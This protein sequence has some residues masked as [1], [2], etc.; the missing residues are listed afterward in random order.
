MCACSKA[1]VIDHPTKP[2]K[3]LKHGA[4]EAP[5]WS[6]HYRGSTDKDHITLPDYW[7]GLV[8]DDSVTAMLTPV[9]EHQNLYVVSQDNNHICVGGVTGCYNYIVYG[10]RK[11]ISKLEVETDG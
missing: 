4:V 9:K 2:G 3:K 11:D 10:E 7:E 1:F 5:E 8:R 6:V